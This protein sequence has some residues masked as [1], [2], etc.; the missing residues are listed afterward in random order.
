MPDVPKPLLRLPRAL[1]YTTIRC[2]ILGALACGSSSEGERRPPDASADALA[3]HDSH[4][5]T[6]ETGSDASTDAS[7]AP[8]DALEAY[9]SPDACADGAITFCGPSVGCSA[10]TWPCPLS[11]AYYCTD[12]CPQGCEPFG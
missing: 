1:A 6:S 2:T 10:D 4:A 8:T 11:G 3:A 5:E 12:Q 7:D 9:D